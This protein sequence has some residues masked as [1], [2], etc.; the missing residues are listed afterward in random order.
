MRLQTLAALLLVACGDNSRVQEVADG[1]TDGTVDAEVVDAFKPMVRV[2][3]HVEANGQ[4]VFAAS[5]TTLEGTQL[6]TTTDTDGNFYF[7]VVEG[8]R[9]IMRVD[10]IGLHD[11]LPMIRGLIAYDHLRVRNFYIIIEDEVIA[12]ES[13]GIEF[14]PTKAIVEVDFRNAAIGGYAATLTPPGE[15][16]LQPAFGIVTD[17]DGQP[18]LGQTT[19]AGGNGSTLLLGGLS[20]GAV[21]F[22]AIVP[23]GA[24]LPC[25]PRDAQPLP[26]EAGVVTW[27]DYEC[28]EGE[29]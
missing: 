14:D 11:A 1:P 25:Q 3:G 19:I 12:A 4:P 15:P 6:S 13:L 8:S 21:D 20:P 18:E 16:P 10:P 22:A 2:F 17:E 9:L 24:T 29:D 7:D 26:L 28:G 23:A 5:V 27:F